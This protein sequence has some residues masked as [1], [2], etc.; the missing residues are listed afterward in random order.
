MTHAVILLATVMAATSVG[1]AEIKV[2][3]AGAVEPG[4]R[5]FAQLV[6]AQTG[7]DLAIQYEPVPHTPRDRLQH[8]HDL[9]KLE[10][11]VVAVPGPE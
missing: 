11:F 2:L 9:R 8:P 7:H 1:A 5:A 10:R 3:S 6:N 4:L